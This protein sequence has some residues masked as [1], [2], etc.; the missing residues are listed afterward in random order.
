MLNI[1]HY[2]WDY[3]TFRLCLDKSNLVLSIS[4]ILN[5][6][7]YNI[8]LGQHQPNIASEIGES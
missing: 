1:C 2:V 3:H 5:C 4:L 7:L 8:F 6:F